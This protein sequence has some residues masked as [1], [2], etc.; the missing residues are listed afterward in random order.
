MSGWR[1]ASVTDD[2]RSALQPI[3]F[4]FYY[5]GQ[6]YTNFSVSTNGFMDLSSSI[7]V[8]TGSGAYGFQNAMFSTPAGTL[9]ALAPFYDDLLTPGGHN[10]QESL[11]ASFKRQVD[12]SPGSRVLTVEWIGLEVGGNSGPDLNFQVKLH[13]ATGVIEYVYGTMNPGTATYTYTL[14]INGPDDI[15]GAFGV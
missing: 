9:L 5:D 12:G 4:T 8:G 3:G 1:N 14:G 6:A 11:D 13:E 7:A 2:N 10:A 15:G